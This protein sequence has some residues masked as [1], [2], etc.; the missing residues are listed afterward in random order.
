MWP[1]WHCGPVANQV[2]LTQEDSAAIEMS[3]VRMADTDLLA[4]SDIVK[5]WVERTRDA[6]SPGTDIYLYAE[7]EKFLHDMTSIIL[8][9]GA[10]GLCLVILV[11]YVFLNGRV[12]WWVMVGIPIS[13][14]GAFALYMLVGDGSL[15]LVM[16][17]ALVMSIRHC[18]GRCHRGRGGHADLP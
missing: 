17:I 14:M 9:N 6:L 7:A 2:A 12:A 1:Q 18:R 15:N 13:F 3:I 4:A 10:S 5:G 11:L 16:M 8:R